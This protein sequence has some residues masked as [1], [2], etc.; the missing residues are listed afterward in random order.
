M[1][2]DLSSRLAAWLFAAGALVLAVMLFGAIGL[3]V[4]PGDAFPSDDVA[5][6]KVHKDQCERPRSDAGVVEV[7]NTWSNLAYL[8]AGVLVFVR[9]RSPAGKVLG[10]NLA[11][12]AV[13]SGWYHA[14]LKPTPQVLDVAWV[15]AVLLSLIM[16]V[17]DTLARTDDL[18]RLGWWQWAIAGGVL[19]VLGLVAALVLKHTVAFV[20]LGLMVVPLV[21]AL[22]LLVVRARGGPAGWWFWVWVA[23]G[24]VTL[25]YLIRKSFDWDSEAV[26][27][28]LVGALVVLLLLALFDAF[29]RNA[30]D[31]LACP[32]WVEIGL[33]L[34]VTGI[35]FFFRLVDGYGDGGERKLLCDPDSL[36]QAHAWWH[37][38]SAV[39]IVLTYDLVAQ[40]DRRDG[41]W[42]P[43]R[44]VLLPER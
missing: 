44:P 13:T 41:P 40:M 42:R 22:A 10:V 5:L 4:K 24:F 17:N 35:G 23:L 14:S 28:I 9:A 37:M 26:F 20:V 7:Q 15:Y 29:A 21:Q 6:A 30:F 3:A 12:L 27:P 43:D 2:A 36:F 11:L 34:V 32:V 16:K 39:A 1:S 19:G 25:G 31:G 8:V 33:V 38:I 18:G